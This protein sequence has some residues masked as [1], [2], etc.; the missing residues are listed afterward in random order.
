MLGLL[1]GILGLGSLRF[2]TRATRNQG[3]GWFTF[4]VPPHLATILLMQFDLDPCPKQLQG[5]GLGFRVSFLF[6]LR[7]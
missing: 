7:L 6:G 1:A 3:M 2:R 5:L 4:G